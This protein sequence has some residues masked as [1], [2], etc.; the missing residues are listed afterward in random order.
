[1]KT[2][3]PSTCSE[4]A[5]VGASA[6]KPHSGASAAER[7]K[8]TDGFS[9]Y[10]RRRVLIVL[11]Q[12][13]SS[14]LPLALSTSTLT[15][16][17]RD[18]G[19][20]LKT[21]GLFALIRTPYTL[22]FF[23]APLVDA[24]DVPL[25]SHWLGRRRGWLLLTQLLL[26]A[27]IAFLAFCDPATSPWWVAFGALLVAI[28][29]ATQDIVIDTFRVESLEGES[30][31]AA[32]VAGSVATYKVA[33]LISTAGAIYV[34][35]AFVH[36]LG[37]AK[38]DAWVAGYLVMAALVM[39]GIVTTLV[40]T[41]PEKS[42]AAEEIHA[43]QGPMQRLATTVAGA[44]MDFFMREGLLTTIVI[45]AFVVL[46]KFTDALSG[47]L[48]G[49]F[50]LDLG[51]STEDYANI[52][53]VVGFW[54]TLTGG[55]LGGF[56]VKRYPIAAM[57]WIG[58]IAQAT[59]HLAFSWSA[60]VGHNIWWLTVAIVTENFTGGIGTVIFVVYLTGLC[61]NPLH[62]ATQ[63]ALFTALSAFGP[64]FL[65][66]GAGYVVAWTGYPWFFVIC[67]M[68]ALPSFVLLAW[69]Q[70]RGHFA[71]PAPALREAT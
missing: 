69:L 37:F 8:W 68:A 11:L 4:P 58:G 36:L 56:M 40:A 61:R 41:E 23:W 51:F 29:S 49:P 54:A 35:S 67:M 3:Y 42:A 64:T 39:V 17:M 12:G 55:F 66:S 15:L 44:F 6:A 31:Q 71:V 30:E 70:W 22:K 19:V 20:D 26:M 21:I 25:L 62:T 38:H 9:V 57:L 65:S 16:W 32:G 60:V 53:K 14:G 48:I 52:I 27:A 63:F 5:P 46:F 18:V 59:A 24:F 43:G 28:A 13:F 47:I 50:V 33:S 10:L 2:V 1:M 45:L 7:Q 34:V